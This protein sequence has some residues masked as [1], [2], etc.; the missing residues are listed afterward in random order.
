MLIRIPSP[1]ME[2]QCEHGSP[3]FAVTDPDANQAHSCSVSGADGYFD[4]EAPCRLKLV[5]ALD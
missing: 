2:Y 4:I 5:A 3:Q 1:S